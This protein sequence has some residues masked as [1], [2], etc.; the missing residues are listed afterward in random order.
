MYSKVI[1]FLKI[2]IISYSFIFS[3]CTSRI[4]MEIERLRSLQIEIPLSN[5]EKIQSPLKM[6]SQTNAHLSAYRFIVFVDS[7]NC[8]PCIIDKIGEWYSIYQKAN[9]IKPVNF[10]FIFEKSEGIKKSLL[11]NNNSSLKF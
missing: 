7:S 11:F 5:F 1:L 8:T 2:L 6:E 10:Y 3:S 4:G 9:K